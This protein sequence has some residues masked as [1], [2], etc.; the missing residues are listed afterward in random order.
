MRLYEYKYFEQIQ[1]AMFMSKT[2]LVLHFTDIPEYENF[3]YNA[4][5]CV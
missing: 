3:N 5:Q 4:M 1:T 2:T